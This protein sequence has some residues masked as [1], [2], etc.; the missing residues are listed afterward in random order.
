MRTI[1]ARPVAI[2]AGDAALEG[3]LRMPCVRVVW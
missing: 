3:D 2:P 1:T